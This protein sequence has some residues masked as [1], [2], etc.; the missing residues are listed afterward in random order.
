[1][2]IFNVGRREKMKITSKDEALDVLNQVK[3][4]QARAKV[5]IS[6]FTKAAEAE[7]AVPLL[8]NI[9]EYLITSGDAKECTGCQIQK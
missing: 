6:P 8:I 5:A 2:H 1:R 9:I 4:G 3:Q 7:K